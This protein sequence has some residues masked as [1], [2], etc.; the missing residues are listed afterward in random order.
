MR[1]AAPLAALGAAAQTTCVAV[2]FSGGRDS[3]ALLHATARAALGLDLQVVALHVHHG[4]MPQADA[5]L[6]STQSLCQRWRRRGLPLRWRGHR[7]STKPDAGESVEAWARRERYA[8]LEQMAREEGASLLLLAHHQRDQA[9]TVVLQ[10]LRGAGPRGLAAMP[11]CLERDGL[12]WA[13]PWLSMPRETIEA[14]VLRHRLRAIEDPS[15]LDERWAR[16]RLR[17]QL[18]P[19]LT[20]AFPGV[21]TALAQVAKRSQEADAVLRELAALDLL[22]CANTDGLQTQPWSLL[23]PAR[24]GNALRQWLRQVLGRG[25]REALVQRLLL[26]LPAC[27]AGNW[28]AAEGR[29]V[30]YRGVLSWRAMTND[31]GTDARAGKPSGA[32]LPLPIPKLLQKPLHLDLSR[33]GFCQVPSWRGAFETRP[34]VAQ[35]VALETLAEVELRPRA[36]GERFQFDLRS[37]PRSLKK[38]YQ[39]AAVGGFDRSGPLVW[40]GDQL[41]F[42]PGLGMDARCWAASTLPQFELIWHPD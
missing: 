4:L 26:E 12:V 6:Q 30:L 7:V 39:A 8:A 1:R 33:P 5:W 15:N 11:V 9:E 38:Q 16:N 19:A 42:A 23:S 29:L 25:A 22:A 18:W 2:A 24:R 40:Q 20:R 27:R 10:A 31:V 37:M 17:L 41:L 32:A 28:Q 21:D 36:G 3:L 34:V 35:G 14:Y 13:R